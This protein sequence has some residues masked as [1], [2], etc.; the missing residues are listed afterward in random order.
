MVVT[1]ST[2]SKDTGALVSPIKLAFQ[3]EL[4][5]SPRRF[6]LCIALRSGTLVYFHHGRFWEYVSPSYEGRPPL[7]AFLNAL[8]LV[9][10]FLS[11]DPALQVAEPHYLSRTRQQLADSLAEPS[12]HSLQWL[13]ASCLLT[14]YLWK[15]CH[16]L[17]A[18]Q[19]V[20]SNRD[21]PEE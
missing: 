13:Q 20:S 10:C 9:G 5:V 2:A 19:E 17:E 1:R 7:P 4:T 16:F 3:R 15:K 18:R 8:Y 6:K 12:T 14:Y 11:N 21:G